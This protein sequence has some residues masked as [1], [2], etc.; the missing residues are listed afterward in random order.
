[1]TYNSLMYNPIGHQWETSTHFNPPIE[2]PNGEGVMYFFKNAMIGYGSRDS[3]TWVHMIW[4]PIKSGS[5][6]IM[7]QDASGA[8]V[9]E[10]TLD[11]K[12]FDGLVELVSVNDLAGLKTYLNQ[13]MVPVR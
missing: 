6:T 11:V 12:Y 13:H 9:P 4:N 3:D 1:M 5:Y 10:G 7:K 2:L 8:F